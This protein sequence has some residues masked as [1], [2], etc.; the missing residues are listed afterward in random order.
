[1]EKTPGQRIQAAAP[2]E[3]VLV[4]AIAP[5]GSLEARKLSKT[6]QF[7]WRYTF[8]NKTARVVVGLYDSA[9]PPKSLKPTLRG[10]SIAA[11]IRAAEELSHSH[12][13]NLAEGG[14]SALLA[15]QHAEKIESARLVKEAADA[16]LAASIYT[17]KS[18][19]T[20]YCDHLKTQGKRSSEDARTI[21][22]LHIFDAFPLLAAKPADQVT[23]EDLSEPLRKLHAALKGRTANKL[24]AFVMAAYNLA[25]SAR[26]VHSIPAAFKHYKISRN[27]LEDTVAD[28][29]ANRADKNPLRTHD[30]RKYWAVIKNQSDF[31]G[32]V[33]RLHLLSGGPR[34]EQLLCLK[35]CDIS[36]DRLVLWDSKGRSGKAR[37]HVLPL[38]PPIAAAL[39]SAMTLQPSD[40]IYALSSDRGK[41]HVDPGTFAGW[42]KAAALTAAISGFMPKRLRSGCET[43]MASMGVSEEV[44]G[45]L[46]SHGLGG[47]QN[48]HYNSH[49]YL[50]EMSKALRRLHATL[51]RIDA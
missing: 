6:V 27:P 32:A 49:D 30:M 48:A 44:R 31:H 33:L 28:A 20:A 26:S 42:S 3:Y 7:Y 46:Q 17:L 21:F 24:R 4:A 47:V 19:L 35:V 11:A 2:G 16:A 1:M 13:L 22:R 36:N 37:E 34:I 51:D 25:K 14:Y 39:E 38:L 43:L 29:A 15:A 50:K 40:G 45:R 23:G 9:A 12:Y 10:Y 41:T 8:K 5:V 18:L